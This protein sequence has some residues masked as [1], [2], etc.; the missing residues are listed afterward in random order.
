MFRNRT[1]AGRRL[2]DQL[3]HLAPENPV[4]VGVTRGGV[5]V[6]AEV[7][8]TLGAPLDAVIV[9]KLGV[10]RQPE[11][12]FGAIGENGIEVL[13]EQVMR[14][15]R[16]TEIDLAA[17]ERH[18]RAHMKRL[19]DHLQSAGDRLEL[20]GRT[21]VVVDDGIAIGTTSLAACEV[22]RKAGAGRVVLAVPVM[23]PGAVDRFADRVDDVVFLASPDDFVG[24]GRFYDDFSQVSDDEVLDLLTRRRGVQEPT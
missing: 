23:A 11:V 3:R 9:R 1:E 24:V 2:G 20:T 16:I 15:A 7:A 10:P 6:A 22:V 8:R 18:E 13:D 21:V 5:P 4:V 19:A 12:G 14:D 17:I